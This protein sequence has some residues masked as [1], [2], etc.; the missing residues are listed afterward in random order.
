[1]FSVCISELFQFSAVHMDCFSNKDTRK[2]FFKK[3]GKQNRRNME[4]KK[5]RGRTVGTKDQS[6]KDLQVQKQMD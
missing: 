1:M 3:I 5:C 6:H 4:R 2:A